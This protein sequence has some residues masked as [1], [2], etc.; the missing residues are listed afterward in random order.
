MELVAGAWK[1]LFPLT[2]KI[3]KKWKLEKAV[4]RAVGIREEVLMD[5]VEGEDMDLSVTTLTVLTTITM[6]TMATITGTTREE[7]QK[8]D[9][10]TLMKSGSHSSRLP[11]LELSCPIKDP[12]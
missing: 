9:T 1:T 4:E 8:V 10:V 3:L 5:M 11:S 6:A 2:M 7:D 12:I